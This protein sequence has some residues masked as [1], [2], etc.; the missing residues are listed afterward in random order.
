M[1]KAI[2]AISA[3]LLA[4][5]LAACNNGLTHVA[6]ASPD[7]SPATRRQGKA[8]PAA[9]CKLETAAPTERMPVTARGSIRFR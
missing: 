7:P 8:L 4:F 5:A 9:A 6:A 1:H 2:F 3:A